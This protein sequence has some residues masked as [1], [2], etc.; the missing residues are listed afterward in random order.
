MAHC[1][2][3]GH[4]A[5]FVVDRQQPQPNPLLQQAQQELKLGLSTQLL[6][7]AYTVMTGPEQVC[8]GKASCLNSN[9]GITPAAAYGLLTATSVLTLLSSEVNVV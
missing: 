5:C 2:I 8:L 3:R 9:T 1:T 6:T 4:L 7:A